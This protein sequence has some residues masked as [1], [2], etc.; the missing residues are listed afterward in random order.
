MQRVMPNQRSVLRAQSY[1]ELDINNIRAR[2]YS[3]GMISYDNGQSQFEVP[4]GDGTHTMFAASLW[5]GG[6]NSGNN[7]CLAAVRFNQVGEDW[8]P[9]R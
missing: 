8:W 9:D 2:F 4:N 6:L 5:M 3:D 1:A 7:L